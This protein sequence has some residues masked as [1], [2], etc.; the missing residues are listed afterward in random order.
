MSTNAEDRNVLVEHSDRVA[1]IT[2]NRPAARN[3]L[4]R[5]LLNALQSALDDAVADS[6]VGA[7]VLTGA[8][9][10]FCAGA[11]LKESSENL[12]SREFWGQYERTTQSMRLQQQLPRLS[13]P[14]IAAVNGPAVAGGCGLA[15]ACDIV[16]SSDKARYGYPEVTHGLVAAMVMVNLSRLLSR[17]QALDLLLS[18]RLIDAQE[19]LQLGMVNRVVT[20]ESLL[21]EA[22][23]YA[24][25]LATMSASALRI[26]KTLFHQVVE[27]D[28]DRALEHARDV[29]QMLRQTSDAQSGTLAFSNKRTQSDP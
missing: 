6:D 3:A 14:V 2:L 10:A 8:G 18:G 5:A 17:R 19:A 1:L 7:I 28:Y 4:N 16:I 15:M 23:A 25:R 22:I 13:K 29:N 26:T 20:H 21:P 9:S 27:L 24:R 11:D 12:V